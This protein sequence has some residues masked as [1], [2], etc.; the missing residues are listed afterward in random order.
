MAN[1]AAENLSR[2]IEDLKKDMGRLQKD[3]Y[4]KLETAG[5]SGREKIMMCKDKLRDAIDSLK[6]QL[7]VK[8]NNAYEN[9]KE[10]STLAMDKG[11]QTIGEKPL[12][13][14][15]IAFCAGAILGVFTN[16]LKSHT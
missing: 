14:V 15:L 3:L 6:E 9:I 4:S 16:K 12:T 7:S 8:A 13:A 1:T 2:E 10:Q 11:R 5:T